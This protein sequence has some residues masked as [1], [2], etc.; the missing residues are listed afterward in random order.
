MPSCD[1]DVI[2]W[3]FKTSWIFWKFP[4]IW[5]YLANAAAFFQFFLLYLLG[6]EFSTTLWSQNDVTSSWR[7]QIVRLCN[8]YKPMVNLRE[9]WWTD[10]CWARRCKFEVLFQL[11][12]VLIYYDFFNN[13]IMSH[14]Q[15]PTG[16]V[17]G[18][19][20]DHFCH[21]EIFNFYQILHRRRRYNGLSHWTLKF[22]WRHPGSRDNV[23]KG[24]FSKGN[25]SKSSWSID[26]KFGVYL[27]WEK[28][29]PKKCPHVTVMSSHEY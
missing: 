29:Y 10:R 22:S 20:K 12:I 26:F 2:S 8:T 17:H 18:F 19:S 24:Q 16:F 13:L 15:N 21:L 25:N 5:A 6:Q 28:V 4:F 23:L 7:H 11:S 27:S 9:T 14:C 1:C 3:I